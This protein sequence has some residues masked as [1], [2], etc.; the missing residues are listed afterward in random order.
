MESFLYL[1]QLSSTRNQP[2]LSNKINFQESRKGKNQKLGFVE[3][4]CRAPYLPVA[5]VRGSWSG[6]QKIALWR[7]G[8]NRPGGNGS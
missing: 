5:R 7:W 6:G 4:F 2:D 3:C 1:C 8:N